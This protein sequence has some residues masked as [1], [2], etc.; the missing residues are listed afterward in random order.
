MMAEEKWDIF[1]L[2]FCNNSLFSSCTW[3]DM[4][5]FTTVESRIKT[6]LHCTS[7]PA[8]GFV[9]A[10]LLHL[11]ET[12]EKAKPSSKVVSGPRNCDPGEHNPQERLKKHYLRQQELNKARSHLGKEVV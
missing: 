3:A 8:L 2:S 1:S 4:Y 7:V 10:L 6:L 11:C 9:P 5:N 12:Q